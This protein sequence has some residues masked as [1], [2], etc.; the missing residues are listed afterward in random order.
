MF[1]SAKR[2]SRIF[3]IAALSIA[4]LMF[5]VDNREVAHVSL[6]P[7]PYM[8]DMPLFLFAVFCFFLG[9]LVAFFCTGVKA[10]RLNGELKAEKKR[11]AALQ[12]QVDALRAE[13]LPAVPAV[14]PPSSS[15]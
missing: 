15:L 9:T 4:F 12:N 6:F 11:S 5:A 2:Y 14:V 3:G 7:L 10:R 13:R 8:A 1:G